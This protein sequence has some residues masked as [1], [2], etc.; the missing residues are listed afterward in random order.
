MRFRRRGLLGK[1]ILNER[2][3]R[4]AEAE[5]K[6]YFDMLPV[7]AMTVDR[8]GRVMLCN[9]KSLEMLGFSEDALKGVNWLAPSIALLKVDGNSLDPEDLPMNQALANS[10]KVA[11]VVLGV[12][13]ADD[14]N[15]AWLSMSA[16]PRLDEGGNVREVVC[17]L[18]DVTRSRTAEAE[19]AIQTFRDRLTSLP[20]RNLF[21]ERL[22]QAI[23]RSD[24]RRFLTAVL[25]LDLDRFKVVNDS[26]SHEAGDQLLI[27][28]AKRLRGCLRPEDT[29][30]RLGGDEFVV[31]FE[32]ILSVTDGLVVADRISQGL[33]QPFHLQGQEVFTTCS[34]GIAV[35]SSLDTVPSELIR[36]AE[37]A[38]YR[39]K[40]K[41]KGSIEIF[42]PSMNAKAL[43]H[44]Q[45]DSEMRRALDRHEYVLHYQPVVGLKTGL[46]EGWE[47]LVRWQHPDLGLVPP[48]EFISLAEETGL[49]VPLGKWVLEAACLQA[50]SW[51]ERFPSDPPRLMN[52]N[53][54]GRQFGQ[55]DLIA[56]VMD[57]LGASTL[58]PYCLKLEITE[59][60]MMRDPLVSL[61]AMKV[62][63]SK[64][65]HLV[66]D[67][68]GT[69]YSSLS[70]LKRFPVDT[71]KVDKSFVDG[72]GKDPESTAIV[73]AVISMAQSL[74]MKVTAEGI[75]TI[76]QMKHLQRLG[77]DQ[78]QGYLFSK[79]LP[80]EAAEELLRRN[81]RW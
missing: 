1:S 40:A 77:C 35:S 21:M 66:I 33:V 7:G 62:F 52:V 18:E 76:D 9:A 51:Q 19:L 32:D 15:F 25:F 72:L 44:F 28:V 50:G 56:T 43:A 58:S 37:V 42:D 61:E 73:A 31:L 75:E 41:G 78:G 55:G 38:M 39:A 68:F 3:R 20:N 2:L 74:G 29:V 53:I 30:A 27:Q 5:L 6:S 80:P 4:V 48:L 8:Q 23:L 49:I 26:L 22:S 14:G 69:G 24:R 36:D 10:R 45:M 34:M 11:G 65:I 64:E 54:S 59:S 12:E 60:V 16:Q 57:A 81:P 17:V 46:I 63:R 47:A 13:R 70:Y 67:D 71:L 79:P